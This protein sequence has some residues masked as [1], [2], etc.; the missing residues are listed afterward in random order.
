MLDRTAKR[1]KMTF[2][3]GAYRDVGKESLLSVLSSFQMKQ[4]EVV[5]ETDVG[6]I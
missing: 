2:S 6:I 3:Y 1:Q 4:R 5:L